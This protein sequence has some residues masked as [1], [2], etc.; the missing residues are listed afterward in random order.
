LSATGPFLG[1]RNWHRIGEQGM[2]NR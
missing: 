2:A 1:G